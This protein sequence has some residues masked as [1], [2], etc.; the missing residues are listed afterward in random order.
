METKLYIPKTIKV[1]FQKREGTF[2]GK[3]AY[4]IYTD[5]KGVLRKETSWQNWRDKKIE[6]LDFVNEPTS[7]FMINKDVQRYNWSHFS[8]NRSYIR[9]HDPRGFEF[10]ITPENLIGILMSG[11]CSRRVLDGKFV[12]SWSGTELVLLPESSEGYQESVSFTKLQGVKIKAVDLKVGHVYQ[13]KK[14]EKVVFL[15]RFP[16]GKNKMY[17]WSSLEKEHHFAYDRSGHLP[18]FEYKI[19]STNNVAHIGE[20]IL[21]SV[22]DNFSFMVDSMNEIS[23]PR[24]Q[25][26]GKFKPYLDE[27]LFGKQWNS[28]EKAVIVA[29]DIQFFAKDQRPNALP[30]DWLWYNLSRRD[31]SDPSRSCFKETWNVVE[32]SKVNV[33]KL[34]G[35]ITVKRSSYYYE[36]SYGRSMKKEIKQLKEEMTLQEVF[37]ML[38]PYYYVSIFDNVLEV[39]DEN[40][41]NSAEGIGA[42]TKS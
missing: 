1:G 24:I 21:D 6:P 25:T 19:E 38:Q 26:G 28:Y 35:Q 39:P 9:I 36:D 32:I 20:C 15:G 5:D 34:N 3:L 42:L 11:D 41:C 23:K 22:C 14:T 33:S 7:G 10:E 31:Y 16:V 29:Y 37:T 4:I 12:Y 2:T 8:S 27:N 18:T 17:F 40:Y 30:E 13:T